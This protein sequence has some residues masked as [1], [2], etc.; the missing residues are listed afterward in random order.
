MGGAAIFIQRQ[1]G[2]NNCHVEVLLASLNGVAIPGSLCAGW[3]SDRYG[4]TRSLAAAC[5]TCFIGN[6]LL[7]F[8]MNYAMILTGRL[9]TGIGFG[10]GMSVI[11]VYLSE[12][13]PK[14]W[15]GFLTTFRY[16]LQDLCTCALELEQTRHD[17]CTHISQ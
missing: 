4:R 9:F 6:L 13:S 11:P 14:R 7:T 3:F 17:H 1:F 12:L 5:I 16:T 15:R 8:G 10:F 2:L